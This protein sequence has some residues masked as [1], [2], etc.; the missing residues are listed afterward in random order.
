MGVPDRGEGLEMIDVCVG[1]ANGRWECRALTA[2]ERVAIV[3]CG[4][5]VV[6]GMDECG[7]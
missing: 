5:R 4:E 6:G 3:E 1:G 2:T 7:V